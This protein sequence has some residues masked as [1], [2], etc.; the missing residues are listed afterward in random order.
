MIDGWKKAS[1]ASDLACLDDTDKRE[2]NEQ[3]L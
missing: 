1:S 2:N 3:P